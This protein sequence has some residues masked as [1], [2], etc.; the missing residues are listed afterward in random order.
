MNSKS[1]VCTLQIKHIADSRIKSYA[2]RQKFVQIKELD[3]VKSH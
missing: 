2:K 1:L 3:V